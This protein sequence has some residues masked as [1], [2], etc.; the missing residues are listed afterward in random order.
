[1]AT[2]HNPV[3][4]EQIEINLALLEGSIPFLSKYA[5]QAA[6]LGLSLLRDV[7]R[8]QLLQWISADQLP[9]RQT[10]KDWLANVEENKD[11]RYPSYQP[12]DGGH[13]TG[14]AYTIAWI[15]LKNV[16]G[17]VDIS[18]GFLQGQIDFLDGKTA[19]IPTV[20]NRQ[21]EGAKL[22]EGLGAYLESV[23]KGIV[24]GGQLPLQSAICEWA[25]T[26]KD[27]GP[28]SYLARLYWNDVIYNLTFQAVELDPKKYASIVNQST[29]NIPFVIY[30]DKVM[31][32]FIQPDES[33]VAQVKVVPDTYA[34]YCSWRY[35][36]KE[37]K[38]TTKPIDFLSPQAYE[39]Q[40]RET[41]LQIS[42]DDYPAGE[43][44]HI[45]F[46]AEQSLHGY[47]QGEGPESLPVHVMADG[48]D[49]LILD[50]YP[51]GNGY[52][53]LT[54]DKGL[55]SDCLSNLSVTV[56]QQ[57]RP[58]QMQPGKTYL[59]TEDGGKGYGILVADSLYNSLCPHAIFPISAEPAL[60]FLNMS[61][62][63]ALAVAVFAK[64]INPDFGPRGRDRN[65][66]LP[67]AVV[68]DWRQGI[69]SIPLRK[70]YR[71]N[72]DYDCVGDSFTS[73]D[74]YPLVDAEGHV[75][76]P[77]FGLEEYGFEMTGQGTTGLQIHAA[78][79]RVTKTGGKS[80]GISVNIWFDDHILIRW[81][82]RPGWHYRV[83]LPLEYE[84]QACIVEKSALAEDGGIA[85]ALTPP[86]VIQ[87]GQLA[88]IEGTKGEGYKMTRQAWVSS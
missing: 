11:N 2:E 27:D 36:G 69:V 46:D 42:P 63:Q 80:E 7:L 39:V 8:P 31:W 21:Q 56:Q 30:A 14:A 40:I 29:A 38:T 75:A 58:R 74:Q 79:V 9:S 41:G 47:H 13:L 53:G 19:W 12:F 83:A 34:F 25:S 57:T 28:S 76:L 72:V 10:I 85:K 48:A 77:H 78:D 65:S 64:E 20:I 1:M 6:E 37:Y 18:K 26:H 15:G 55:I 81:W 73:S 43:A 66:Q 71:L 33:G 44:V 67:W 49:I 35:Q 61:D 5:Y 54:I 82:I 24:D 70:A 59:L 68:D 87:H 45:R 3:Q 86:V 4:R 51:F 60:H 22:L 23:L 50:A 88:V 62:N 52:Y 16:I 84:L 17:G 32:K